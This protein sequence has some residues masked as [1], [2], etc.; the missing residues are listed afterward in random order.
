MFNNMKFAHKILLLPVIA[1]LAL[2]TI[3]LIS[4]LAVT[5]NE[6]LLSEI[7]DSYFPASEVTRQLRQVLADFQRD[8]RDSVTALDQDTFEEAK[9]YQQ[10]FLRLLETAK[11]NP[12]LAA[13]T[14]E[15]LQNNFTNYNELALATTQRLLNRETGED[16]SHQIEAMTTSYNNLLI[17]L[18]RLTASCD[19]GMTDAFAAAQQN[20]QSSARLLQVIRWV[21]AF[22]LLSLIVF[23]IILIRS[24]TQP[25]SQAVGVAN[26][27]A[28]GNLETEIVVSSRDEVGQLLLAM[29][30]MVA[31]LR[32]MTNVAKAIAGGD[33]GI[34]VTQRSANDQLGH[35]LQVMAEKLSATIREVRSGVRTLNSASSQVSA[36][37]QS[38][39]QG[40]SEQAAS[41][42]E[43]TS[44]LE[45][46]TAS[47]SQNASSSRKMERMAT[48]GAEDAES[49]GSAVIKT[50]KAMK[51]I[52]EKISIV[53]DIAYQTNLLALNAAIEAAR[54]G[55]HGRGFA[56]V[57]AEVRKLAERS[58]TSAKEISN[59]TSSCLEVA[60]HSGKLLVD[61]V[62]SIR[63]TAD[64]VQE[65]AAASE[66]QSSGVNQINGAM[67]QVDQV[68]Q[69]N[70]SAAEELS[71]TSQEMASQA[72]SLDQLMAL[73]Q[74]DSHARPASHA[75]SSPT[76]KGEGHTVAQPP[77]VASLATAT[78]HPAIVDTQE[79][80]DFERF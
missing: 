78:S 53:E 59:L 51:S 63:S 20:Q 4:P 2:L 28:V 67:S 34:K 52:A 58:Q 47:I 5:K 76:T 80:K 57:A 22:C 21:S 55:D 54:A 27:L 43:A 68:A 36:T 26:Q 69:R 77:S 39:S 19:Q 35:A 44:S 9:K 16:I 38:L 48:Q 72:Q 29:R 6:I 32:D 3:V 15:E 25:L 11:S 14:L 79:D 49:S 71:T 24:V 41:V 73:F 10:V 13:G 62:P 56:V 7:E 8:L 40:T 18:D 37:A 65:V 75:Q 64:L 66:E 74:L 60:E 45:E 31:Y 23:S 70:A 17:T 12:T 50:V 1:G 42:E 30:R 61:L 33:L 46:M